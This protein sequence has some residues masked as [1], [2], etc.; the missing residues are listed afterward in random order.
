[1]VRSL[2]DVPATILRYVLLFVHEH[3][4]A[5]TA[6]ALQS[7]NQWSRAELW[8]HTPLSLTHTWSKPPSAEVAVQ[9]FQ[10]WALS[11][12]YILTSLTVAAWDSRIVASLGAQPRL[13]GLHICDIATTA[14][15]TPSDTTAITEGFHQ[16]GKHLLRLRLGCGW[17]RHVENADLQMLVSTGFRHFG[18]LLELNIKLVKDHKIGD[19]ALLMLTSLTSLN[20]C[21][22]QQKTIT[23]AGFRN[24][25]QLLTLNMTNASR[26][27]GDRAL[28][29][30]TNLTSLTMRD[31]R[32]LIS[33]KA[34]CN[35]GPCLVQLDIG[36]YGG[37]GLNFDGICDD[38]F[39]GLTS[40]TS[41][42]M[43][44]SPNWCISS[45]AFKN[46]GA[47]L[48]HLDLTLCTQSSIGDAA[49]ET[50]TAL[51]FL[52]LYGCNHDT[53]T[54]ACIRNCKQLQYL[55][56]PRCLGDAAL[57][58]I[59]TLTHLELCRCSTKTYA[60]C[61]FA[62]G[63]RPYVEHVCERPCP[64]EASLGAFRRSTQLEFEMWGLD[65]HAEL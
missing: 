42:V 11:S 8:R 5:R 39:W 48:L 41:L 6:M 14:P 29:M 36:G 59:A 56:I 20:I 21:S 64:D 60:Q 2:L 52:S 61:W 43:A 38:A 63:E 17:G 3:A 10:A 31:C 45:N 35:F 32:S 65:R 26:Y 50:L 13:Q 1:M 22:C 58:N 15:G 25:G 57:Q 40:L 34:F 18:Q 7:L 24:F 33:S 62:F 53:F 44:S 19:A 47:R 28:Q 16:L 49:L 51:T 46:L 54:T 55:D 37:G 23:S 9:Y 30:L 12:R 27:I 4:R